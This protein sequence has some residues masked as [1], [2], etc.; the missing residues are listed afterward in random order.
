M[1]RLS[2]TFLVFSLFTVPSEADQWSQFRGGRSDGIARSD[3]PKTWDQSQSIR[4]K[5]PVAGEGWSCPIVWN[6]RVFLTS[7]VNLDGETQPEPYQGGGGRQRSDLLQENYRWEVLCLDTKTGQELWRKTARE[8]HPTMP[9]HSSN[10]Y[11]T[12]TPLTDGERVYAYFGMAGVYCYDLNGE[13]LWQKDLGVYDMRAGWG[14]SSSP[15]LF[16]GK[17]FIQVDNEDQSFLVALE[18]SSGEEM[19]RVQRDERSQYSSPII[20][21]NS[22]RNEL[23]AGGMVYR[24][25]DP[26]TG[27]LLWELDMEKGRSS[28]TPLAVADRLYVGT[29]YRN[30]GGSDDGGGFLFSIK[31]GGSG[32]ISP[33]AGA[34]ATEFIEWKVERSGIQMAS[35]VLCQGHIY[36]LER[37]SGILNC[38]NAETGEVAYR[39]RIPKSRPF[40]ASPWTDG[41]FVYCLD[42][43]GTTHVLKGG[44]D[45]EVVAQNQLDEQTWSSPAI[46]DGVIYLRTVGHLYC[47]A[48]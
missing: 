41:E 15:V 35:P 10:S 23:I 47:I 8:G 31:P 38:V 40:W 9:R 2:V 45:L 34:N 42:D 7:A 33:P 6:D 4:W 27:Q 46:V 11:A 28:A 1:T 24:S 44:P 25:Y 39:E 48:Q 36:L 12:E 29:E 22:Q 20:W 3:I 26:E 16:E 43:Q 14:T 32:D 19:W 37:R 17:L 13:Q 5:V 30:R 21:Q 18:A